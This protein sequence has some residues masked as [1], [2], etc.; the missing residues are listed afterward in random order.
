MPH[1]PGPWYAEQP[2]AGFSALR[3]VKDNRLI[4]A[5]AHPD[6]GDMPDEEKYANLALLKASPKLYST[7]LRILQTSRDADCGDH[8][9]NSC[10]YCAARDAIRKA[11]GGE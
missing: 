6:T 7:L 10:M 3:A 4:F 9:P 2:A 8:C 1:T 11:E 5:L